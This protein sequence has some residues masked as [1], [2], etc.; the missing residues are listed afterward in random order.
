MS[1]D[2][3]TKI[4][5]VTFEGRQKVIEKIFKEEILFL[6]LDYDN[7]HDENAVKVVTA[8]GDQAGFLN[9]EL[10]LEV[11]NAMDKGL[12][13]FC[14]VIALTGGEEVSGNHDEKTSFGCNIRFIRMDTVQFITDLP[15]RIAKYEMAVQ[16]KKLQLDT[17]NAEIRRTESHVA[18]RVKE[19]MVTD[20][21]GGKAKKRYSNEEQRNVAADAILSSDEN[22][23]WSVEERQ[24]KTE[25]LGQEQIMLDYLLNLF[26]ALRVTYRNQPETA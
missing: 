13:Y 7:K 21:E 14:E 16:R 12:N 20:A 5:G 17:L 8:K 6:E 1:N 18:F 3:L 25:E 15:R 9:K 23:R 10:A 4:V 26:K 2:V 19:E 24:K 11:R 22:Y